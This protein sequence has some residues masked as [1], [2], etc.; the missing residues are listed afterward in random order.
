MSSIN[1]EIDLLTKIK[2]IDLHTDY[3]LWEPTDQQFKALES[4]AKFTLFGGARGGGKSDGSIHWLTKRVDNPNML[5]LPIVT[6]KL[7]N[8]LNC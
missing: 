7:S 4:F 8:A 3:T 1:Y 6:G 2:P 5:G